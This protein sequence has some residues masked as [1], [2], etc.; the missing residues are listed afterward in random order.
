MTFLGSVRSLLSAPRA[1]LRDKSGASAIEFAFV[2]PLMLVMYLGT[3]ELGQG[4]E[5]NKKVARS[6]SMIGD[7]IT[8]ETSLTKSQI[9]GVLVVGESILQPY[10]R[11]R[12]MITITALRFNNASPPVAT[13]VWRRK[14]TNGAIT[15]TG[16][17]TE[18]VAVPTQLRTAGSFLVKV[19]TD[20]QYKPVLTWNSDMKSFGYKSTF[21]N[22]PMMET[23]FLRPRQSAEVTCSDC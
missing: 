15:G 17:T 22:I 7:L 11:S 4:I 8:Q 9:D 1:F 10:Y 13:V 6:A 5:T 18:T 23:Y 14:I 20:L 21:T 2:V 3:M 19:E 16:A 12:P